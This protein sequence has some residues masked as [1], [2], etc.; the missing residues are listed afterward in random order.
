MIDPKI[1]LAL[2]LPLTVSFYSL[3]LHFMEGSSFVSLPVSIGLC[4][5]FLAVA[6]VVV[7]HISEEEEIKLISDHHTGL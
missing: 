6:V 1:F 7:M 5:V 3:A 4:A 2:N